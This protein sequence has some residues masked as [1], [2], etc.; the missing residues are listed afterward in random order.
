MPTR[1]K[2]LTSAAVRNY[3][4]YRAGDIAAFD[5][6]TAADLLRRG[7]VELWDRA[8]IIPTLEDFVAADIADMEAVLVQM[9]GA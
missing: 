6:T 4:A 8:T 9:Q 7:V 5:D 3:A 2:F 1:V